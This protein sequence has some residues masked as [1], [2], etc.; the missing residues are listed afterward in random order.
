MPLEE[1]LESSWK[2][3]ESEGTERRAKSQTHQRERERESQTQM[4]SF[5]DWK[6]DSAHVPNLL[7]G[8]PS[9]PRDLKN[10]STRG[11]AVVCFTLSILE[12]IDEMKKKKKWE[13]LL[14]CGMREI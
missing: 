1:S 13:G 12:Q 11:H 10:A 5:K 14:Y 2:E 4:Q 7:M 6:R 3:A 9:S 8:F